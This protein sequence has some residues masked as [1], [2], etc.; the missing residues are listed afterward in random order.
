MRI[1][2]LTFLVKLPNQWSEVNGKIQERRNEEGSNKNNIKS[3]KEPFLFKEKSQKLLSYAT[4]WQKILFFY[5][6]KLKIYCL[7]ELNKTTIIWL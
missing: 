4:K 2:S 6:K 3:R 1:A 5:K 7:M